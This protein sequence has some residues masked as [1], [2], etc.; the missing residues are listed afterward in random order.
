MMRPTGVVSKKDIGACTSRGG[1][2]R[3]DVRKDKFQQ[4]DKWDNGTTTTRR[5]TDNCEQ[6]VEDLSGSFEP[7]NHE[8]N[9][10]KKDGENVDQVYSEGKEKE[11]WLSQCTERMSYL[12]ITHI[13]ISTI[14]THNA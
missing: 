6:V 5:L 11:K 7:K 14:H 2:E 12:D 10:S 8:E 9:N 1:E 3:S 4:L 13:E